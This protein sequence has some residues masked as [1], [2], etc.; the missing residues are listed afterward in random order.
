VGLIGS[1]GSIE[2]GV[3]TG[4]WAAQDVPLVPIP[5]AAKVSLGNPDIDTSMFVVL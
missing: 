3:G 1:S 2:G 4:F 5:A